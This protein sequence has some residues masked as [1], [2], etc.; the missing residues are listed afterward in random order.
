MLTRIILVLIV[1]AALISAGGLTASGA[2]PLA[3]LCIAFG[4]LWLLAHRRR[5]DAAASLCLLAFIGAAGV[6]VNLRG[7]GIWAPLVMVL[8]LAAWDLGRFV[9]RLSGA[10]ASDDTHDLERRHLLRLAVV[11]GLG[12]ALA[13]VAL[14]ARLKL[15]L[16]A[17]LLLGL[18]AILGLSQLVRA[19][20]RESD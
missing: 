8:A 5:W 14:V 12:L 4:A 15:D 6:G 7:G 16:A 1:L 3:L 18:L 9:A 19:L 13:W 11:S 20:A 17:L 10:G 2:W